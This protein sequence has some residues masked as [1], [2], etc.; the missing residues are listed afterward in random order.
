LY[1]DALPMLNLLATSFKVTRQFLLAKSLTFAT[2]VGVTASA[3][4]LGLSQTLVLPSRNCE[5]QLK[6]VE[7]DTHLSENIF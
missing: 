3:G 5:T 1:A 4:L 2:I 6:K 7:R